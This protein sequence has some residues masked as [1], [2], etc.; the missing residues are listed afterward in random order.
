MSFGEVDE[1]FE[2]DEFFKNRWG[3]WSSWVY[4]NQYYFENN[5]ISTLFVNLKI[6]KNHIFLKK[7]L[8]FETI[9]LSASLRFLR[10]RETYTLMKFTLSGVVSF[11][12]Q[13]TKTIHFQTFGSISKWHFDLETF[14]CTRSLGLGFLLPCRTSSYVVWVSKSYILQKVPEKGVY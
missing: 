6:F 2:V 4:G 7:N 3:F 1:C 5:Y 8:R 14:H 13:F 12:F 11:N 9:Y 10:S